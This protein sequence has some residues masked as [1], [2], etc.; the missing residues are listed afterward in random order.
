MKTLEEIVK[1][2]KKV[3]EHCQK[4]S[5]LL[6]NLKTFILFY[7]NDHKELDSPFENSENSENS[8]LLK[9]YSWGFQSFI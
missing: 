3:Y 8:E 5:D 7:K 9:Q 6:F 4:M 2:Q 1:Q